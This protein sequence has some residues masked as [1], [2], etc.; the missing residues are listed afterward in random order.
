MTTRDTQLPHLMDEVAKLG[1]ARIRRAYGDWTTPEGRVWAPALLQYAVEPVQEFSHESGAS[2]A[3]GILIIDAME[4]VYEQRVDTVCLVSSDPGFTRLAIRL[5]K[6]GVA[7]HGFGSRS[8][9]QALV[10]ACDSFVRL[11]GADVTPPASRIEPVPA[12][13]AARVLRESADVPQ[14]P[15]T[16]P[17]R[18][19][20]PQPAG[21]GFVEAQNAH[22][23]LP[24]SA[25]VPR[26]EPEVA[27]TP[28]PAPEG[29]F[30]TPGQGQP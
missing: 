26:R 27:A 22:R 4:L 3:L 20:E 18:G 28:R 7:V 23:P 30:T 1:D 25:A 21:R 11:D 2:P 15:V 6:Q 13:P 24:P 5:R 29:Q 16:A 17:W 19:T 9:P 14:S 8:T 10:A 12:R